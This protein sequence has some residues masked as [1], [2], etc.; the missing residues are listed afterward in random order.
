MK[1]PRRQDRHGHRLRRARRALRRGRGHR[2]HPR[3]RHGGD[4]RARPRGHDGAG[5]DGGDAVPDARPSPARRGGRS[6]SRDMPFGS[7]QVSDEDAVT[8]RDPLRQGGAAPTSSS[9]RARGR[10]LSRVRA[11]V[12]AGIPV[13]GHIGLT[14]QS[15]TMLGG[16]KTQGRTAAKARAARR[17][18]R[19]RSRRPAA[20]RS[21]SRRCRRRS[22]RGSPSALD[23]P[24]DRH[25][26]RAP[27]ATGRC[28]CT[29]TCSASTE[30]HLPRFVKRYAN[31]SRE[32]RDALEAY[33]ATSA[34]G[35]FPEER[36]HVRDAGR[37]ARRVR[38]GAGSHRVARTPL[39]H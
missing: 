31:L 5:D 29:T 7:Y 21:C 16:F 18:T 10:S 15:A 4:G 1:R 17:A 9:S 35:A 28:S 37:G 32:I 14:P 19:W 36:A 33:A 38:G 23:D 8:Q 27:T 34:S 24:D 20:S 2:R 30:G 13:M 39:E 26:R 12:D 25:R 6:S 22:R 3:R 11:I